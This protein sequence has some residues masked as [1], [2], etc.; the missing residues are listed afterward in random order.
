M[1]QVSDVQKHEFLELLK[2]LGTQ[3][4]FYT[5]EAAKMA[6]P[7]LPVLFALT[8]KD[9]EEQD[10]YPFIALSRALCDQNEQRDYAVRHFANIKHPHL[11]LFWGAVLFDSGAASHEIQQFLRKALASKAQERVLSE[12]IGPKFES[13][14]KR[15]LLT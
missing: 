9:I 5:D 2:T 8:D 11:K 10:I 4:E 6:R 7:Y 1:N 3:G 14:K 15:V 12:M 13:F